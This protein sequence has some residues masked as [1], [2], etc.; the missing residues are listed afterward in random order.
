[1]IPVG[2]IP[3]VKKVPVH[4]LPTIQSADIPDL[5][6]VLWQETAPGLYRV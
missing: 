2:E 1:M 4:I 3:D 6:M 5:K